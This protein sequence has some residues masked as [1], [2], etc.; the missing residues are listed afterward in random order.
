MPNHSNPYCFLIIYIEECMWS[1]LWN[2]VSRAVQM[3]SHLRRKLKA[4]SSDPRQLDRAKSCCNLI[5]QVNCMW[6]QWGY[7]GYLKRFIIRWIL[8]EQNF[9]QDSGQK[10]NHMVKWDKFAKPKD[11]GDMG[12]T[13]TRLMNMCLL[14][15]WIFKL[16]RGD[17]DL[18]YTLFRKNTS[19][20]KFFL[21]VTI[22]GLHNSG[23]KGLDEA[24]P[25]CRRGLKH[26]LE[27]GRKIRFC[28]EV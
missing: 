28:H 3:R 11:H 6:K 21:A 4:V 16:E 9:Y 17:D 22:E 25:F 13:D 2:H 14:S 1:T 20:A 10:T 24:K 15:R 5:T 7:S 27:N 23:M 26:I 8:S 19:H 18:C 12:F